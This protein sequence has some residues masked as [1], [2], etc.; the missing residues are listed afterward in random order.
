MIEALDTP[1]SEDV[2]GLMF[3]A[4]PASGLTFGQ[5]PIGGVDAPQSGALAIRA[6]GPNYLRFGAVI[7]REVRLKMGPSPEPTSANRMVSWELCRKALEQRDV[8]KCDRKRFCTIACDMVFIPDMDDVTA[9]GVRASMAV[10]D[11]LNAVRFEVPLWKKVFG[12]GGGGL[13][14]G[15]K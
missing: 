8:R 6:R 7:A 4:V 3:G 10:K 5:I 15:G 1:E 12:F 2:G 9:A 11:R 14:Y 13:V